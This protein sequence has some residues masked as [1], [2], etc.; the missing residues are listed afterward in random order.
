MGLHR[1]PEEYGIDPVETH[2]RRII[3]YQLCFLDLK[4]CDQQGPRPSIRPDDFST[5]FPLNVDDADFR[6]PPSPSLVDRSEFTDMTLALLRFEA[7]ELNRSVYFDRALIEKES[8]SLTQIVSKVEARRKAIYAKYGPMVYVC[9]PLPIHRAAQLFLSTSI[10]SSYVRLLHPFLLSVKVRIPDRLRQI[11][12]SAGIQQ[13]ETAIGLEAAPEMQPWAWYLGSCQQYHTAFLLLFEVFLNPMRRET[14]RIWRCLDYVFETSPLPPQAE[15]TG[16]SEISRE[17]LLAHRKR[18]GVYVIQQVL[19]RTLAFQETRK[20][21]PPVKLDVVQVWLD[22]HLE[23]QSVPQQK[24]SDEPFLTPV[25][26]LVAR[27]QQSHSSELPQTTLDTVMSHTQATPTSTSAP[28]QGSLDTPSD[29]QPKQSLPGQQGSYAY[30]YSDSHHALRP[31]YQTHPDTSSLRPP[32]PMTY[33]PDL[34]VHSS[35]FETT[36]PSQT[37]STNI[38]GR[39]Q[40][41]NRSDGAFQRAV[42]DTGGGNSRNMPQG[43]ADS[44]DLPMLDIDWVRI[45]FEGNSFPLNRLPFFVALLCV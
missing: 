39:E 12:I 15:N 18:K 17:E 11:I 43:R 35:T 10:C 30:D 16:C 40:E 37:H 4:T 13:L 22:A 27:G 38:V 3:W 36:G 26:D 8:A 28:F 5:K 9:N 25:I 41:H 21:K 7:N 2:V 33:L 23:P 34:K 24:E 29:E 20:P 31:S 45:S 1:D 14:D 6:L 44:E 42:G 32:E 19:D